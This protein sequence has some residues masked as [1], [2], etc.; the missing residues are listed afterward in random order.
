V[1]ELTQSTLTQSRSRTPGKKSRWVEALQPARVIESYSAGIK[2]ALVARGEADVYLNTYDAFHDWDIAAGHLL[3]TEAGG[4]VTGTG[5]EELRY[6]LEGA[7]QKHGLLA[8]NG[9]VHEAALAKIR[10]A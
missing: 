8:T 6:G 7:W 9:K 5:G 1:A 3:V 4:K 2:L 10:S